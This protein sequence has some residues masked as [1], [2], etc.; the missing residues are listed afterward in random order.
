MASKKKASGRKSSTRSEASQGD[1]QPVAGPGQVVLRPEEQEL[2]D[3]ALK[4]QEDEQPE[5]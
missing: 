4:S 3:E 1:D 2:V 5:S